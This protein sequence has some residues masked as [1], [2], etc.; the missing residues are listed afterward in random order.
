M[1]LDLEVVAHSD[2]R[3]LPRPN[4]MSEPFWAAA[5]RH[6]LRLQRCME[7]REIRYYPRPRCP[8]CQ[9]GEYEW[10]KLSGQ[11][12]VYTYTV[13]HRPVARW[14]MDRV[15]LVCAIVE[16]KEGVRV[17]SDL[18]EIEPERVDIGMAVEAFFEDVNEEIS[19]LKFRP[20]AGRK[21]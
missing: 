13:V 7:C 2:E 19:L 15:P 12:S 11:G 4:A 8:N 3:P 18:E 20:V 10:E 5:R 17:L 14:F 1:P 6:E 9:S 21:K 16:L